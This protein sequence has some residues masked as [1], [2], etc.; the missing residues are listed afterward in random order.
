MISVSPRLATTLPIAPANGVL[1]N[2]DTDGNEFSWKFNDTSVGD[3]QTAY[4]LILTSVATGTLAYDTGKVNSSASAMSTV[5]A[6]SLKGVSLH[7][8][9]RTWDNDGTVGPYSTSRTVTFVDP[10]VITINSPTQNAT[11]LTGRPTLSWTLGGTA[12]QKSFAL[13]VM[14]SASLKTVYSRTGTTQT[15]VIP[16]QNVLT[17]T[18]SYVFTVN[19]VTTLGSKAKASTSWTASYQPPDPP[20]YTVDP[21][22]YDQFGYID[23][24]WASAIADQFNFTWTVSRRIVGADDWETLFVTTN[25]DVRDYHDWTAI[26]GIA[27]EYMVSQDADRS[28]VLLGSSFEDPEPYVRADSGNWWFIDPA[29]ES[30]NF[31]V[32]VTDDSFSDEWEENEYFVVGRGRVKDVGTHL[33]LT[34]SVTAQIRGAYGLTARQRFDALRDMRG[35]N[36]LIVMRDPFGNFYNMT[37]GIVQYSHVAGTGTNEQYNVTIPVSE[38]II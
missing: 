35:Q 13:T 19:I 29:D 17:N 14:D 25:T 27:Y 20:D 24:N 38:V 18:H 33:G 28:G 6:T 9:V 8:Q 15:T 12:A 11:V 26:T 22:F 30:N 7:W 1:V 36:K 4:Q 5:I 16:P 21:G 34:G 32:N 2:Y 3:Q 10:A 31:Y 37:I 23:I